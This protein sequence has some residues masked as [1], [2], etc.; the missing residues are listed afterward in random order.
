MISIDR[1][2]CNG[3]GLCVEVCPTGALQLIERLIQVDNT[4]CQAC[5]LC[6][7]S[8]P[9]NALVSYTIVE[10]APALASRGLMGAM[11][12]ATTRNP[13]EQHI[14]KPSTID[15][16]K[17]RRSLGDWLGAAFHFLVFDLAP[18]IEGIIDT[19][20][21]EKGAPSRSIHR[22]TSTY[23]GRRGRGRNGRKARRRRRGR[24]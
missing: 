20:Q 1:Q 7:D 15:I 17:P 4:L 10:E 8:C 21:R 12:A 6:V 23:E 14:S 9:Q 22:N 24:W 19:N 16:D 2:A 5:E 13:G 18:V 3:C 11:D